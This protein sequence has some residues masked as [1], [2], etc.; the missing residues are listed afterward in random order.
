VYLFTDRVSEAK[1]IHSQYKMQNITSNVSW[2]NQTKSDFSDF[3]KNGFTTD[4]FKKILK[5]I[6]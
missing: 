3:E 6:E 2:V 4:N 1:D 5:I